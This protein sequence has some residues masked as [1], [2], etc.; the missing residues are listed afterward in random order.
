VTAGF[1]FRVDLDSYDA[2]GD[3]V[4]DDTIEF[5]ELGLMLGMVF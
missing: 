3:S 2:D 1:K 4:A 5:G